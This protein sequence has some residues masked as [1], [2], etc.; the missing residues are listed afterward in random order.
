MADIPAA[1][2]L[3]DGLRREHAQQCT[4]NWIDY[5]APPTRR[6]CICNVREWNARIEELRALLGGEREVAR[7]PGVV[8]AVLRD[9]AKAG[10]EHGKDTDVLVL[11][12]EPQAVR[13]QRIWFTPWSDV[14]VGDAV[15]VVV[16]TRDPGNGR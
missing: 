6:P 12:D 14:K 7:T 1:L 11:L 15:S 13:P 5:P 16:M 8:K 2:R 3:L 4:A 10:R 9:D